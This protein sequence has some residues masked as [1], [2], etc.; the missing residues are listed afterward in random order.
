MVF[1]TFISVSIFV[2]AKVF[3]TKSPQFFFLSTLELFEALIFFR[4]AQKFLSLTSSGSSSSK[5]TSLL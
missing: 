2:L 3:L 1:P 5:V 4:K